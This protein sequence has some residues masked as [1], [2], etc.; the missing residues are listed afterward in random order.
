MRSQ[1]TKARAY[2][3]VW[4]A[5]RLGRPEAFDRPA[6]GEPRSASGGDRASRVLAD[7]QAMPGTGIAGVSSRGAVRSLVAGRAIVGV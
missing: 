1:T 2:E 6:G 5:K 7:P 3:V 4:L